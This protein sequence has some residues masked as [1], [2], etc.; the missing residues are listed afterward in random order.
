MAQTKIDTD[1]LHKYDSAAVF[2][3]EAKRHLFDELVVQPKYEEQEP[4][5]L[6]RMDD[7][8]IYVPRNLISRPLGRM[9]KV[10]L[11]TD[12]NC[13]NY[14]LPRSSEQARMVGKS[15]RLLLKGVDHI[16]QAPTG[17]GKTYIGSAVAAEVGKRTLIITT[18]EDCLKQWSD[19]VNEVMKINPFIWRGSDAPST[20]DRV[21]VGL[22]Q[23]IRKGYERYGQVPYWNYGLVI[24]DEV[25]RMGA[26]RFSE[27]MWYLPAKHRLGLSATP[28]RKDGRAGVFHA[29][30]GPVAVSTEMETA[31]PKIIVQ[32]TGART[33]AIPHKM[34]RLGP[35]L[36]WLQSQPVRNKYIV[37]FLQSCVRTGR[38]TIVFSEYLKHLDT[39]REL[40]LERGVSEDDIGYYVGLS[41]YTGKKADK[42][43]HREDAKTKPIVLA[44]YSMASE[45]T[46]IPWLDTAVLASPRSD[47][48]QIVGRIRREWPDKKEPVVF[49]LVDGGS[50][51]LD[52]YYK[53]RIRLYK[54]WGSKIVVH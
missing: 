44:T 7:K 39:I 38:S 21:V 23:S 52:V 53:N 46:D 20:E 54:S 8:Y 34:G 36:K 18:K 35:V 51:V 47:V 27:A 33:P 37:D 29:H 22:V 19:A 16:M 26:D 14:F 5:H 48:K 45:A 41:N 11:G 25:H 12:L 1:G 15:K 43:K 30:I 9:N 13:A 49:D 6:C 32:N 17:F 24:C 3:L 10:H 42:L 2:H 50:N 4:F 40:L 31:I 28:Y